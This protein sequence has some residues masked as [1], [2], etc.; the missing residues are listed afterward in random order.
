M[1]PQQAVPTFQRLKGQETEP[2]TAWD[3]IT[4]E[5]EAGSSCRMIGFSGA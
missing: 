2:Q 4:D 1:E 3:D 5:S